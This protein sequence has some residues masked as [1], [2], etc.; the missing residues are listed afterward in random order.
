MIKHVLM[1]ATVT[2]ATPALAQTATVQ[3]A[4]N[5]SATATSAPQ[6]TTQTAGDPAA[7]ATVQREAAAKSGQ[8]AASADAAQAATPGAAPEQQAQAGGAAT[9]NAPTQV[10]QVV[11]HDFPTYDKDAN[12]ALSKAEFGEW[13]VALRSASDPSFKGG[14]PAAT[15]W[16]S[17]AFAMA[18]KDK[19][20]TV[21]QTELTGFLSKGQS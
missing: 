19:S 5:G 6:A 1:A 20:R 17:Q 3:N 12:G 11:Q 8:Q 15:T 21:S 9:T 16:V 2:I 7:D 10:A 4:P 13:M 18:D 14:T